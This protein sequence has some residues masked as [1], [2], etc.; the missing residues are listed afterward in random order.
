MESI[1]TEPTKDRNYQRLVA[2]LEEMTKLYRQLLD[3][4][5]KEKQLLIEEIGRAHV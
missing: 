2:N 3:L 5:R 1:I 4:V